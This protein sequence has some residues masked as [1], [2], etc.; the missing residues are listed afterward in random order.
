MRSSRAE[1][2]FSHH[3]VYKGPNREITG[4][5]SDVDKLYEN[6]KKRKAKLSSPDAALALRELYDS[7]MGLTSHDLNAEDAYAQV[8]YREGEDITFYNS[9]ASIIVEFIALDMHKILGI[10]IRDYLE[11]T[12]REVDLYHKYC[13]E[14]VKAMNAAVQDM[15]EETKRKQK[16]AQQTA[17]SFSLGD[18]GF[19]I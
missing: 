6:V 17:A 19:D 2:A 5:I 11:A 16:E 3:V 15:Q 4:L 7:A 10:S 9:L 12:P 1:G 14:R 8:L 13:E 18:L